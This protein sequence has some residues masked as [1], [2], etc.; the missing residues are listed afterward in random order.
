MAALIRQESEFDP[1][2]VSVT[3]ARGLTQVQP[4]TGKDLAQRLKLTFT[5]AK[6]F[7]PEYNLQLGTFYFDWL[8]QQLGGDVDA[9]LA[10]YNAGMSRAKQWQ[11][12]GDFREPAEFIETIPITQT[13]DYVQAVRRNAVAYARSTELPRSDGYGSKTR[14]VSRASHARHHR[15]RHS[16]D[17]APG[18]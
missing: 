9:V 1:D 4:T 17:V 7:V 16:R 14:A 5:A 6:L 13:R 3:G 18:D 2:V 12:W 8:T 10:S 11:K 15:E